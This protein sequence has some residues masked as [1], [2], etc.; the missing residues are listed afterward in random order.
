MPSNEVGFM[1]GIGGAHGNARSSLHTDRPTEIQKIFN[2]RTGN[3]GI[4]MLTEDPK[5]TNNTIPRRLGKET[6]SRQ[7]KSIVDKVW[8]ANNFETKTKSSESDSVHLLRRIKRK[9]SPPEPLP[10]IELV[11]QMRD[12]LDKMYKIPDELLAPRESFTEWAI[13]ERARYKQ[14]RAALVEKHEKSVTETLSMEG[15]DE[16]EGYDSVT[17]KD[18]IRRTHRKDIIKHISG[19]MYGQFTKIPKLP[20]RM[21]KFG[22]PLSMLER[23][24][25][26]S[27]KQQEKNKKLRRARIT[28]MKLPIFFDEDNSEEDDVMETVKTLT[29][30]RTPF[31]HVPKI[32]TQK[33]RRRDRLRTKYLKQDRLNRI[34]MLLYDRSYIPSAQISLEKIEKSESDEEINGIIKKTDLSNMSPQHKKFVTFIKEAFDEQVKMLHKEKTDDATSFQQFKEAD[35]LRTKS[36]TPSEGFDFVAK[37]D[38]EP[39]PMQKIRKNEKFSKSDEE[40]G[41]F[42]IDP[43]KIEKSRDPS[44][45]E[46]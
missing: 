36:T 21:T 35:G 18:T 43:E 2:M 14:K 25:E 27:E 15:N 30:I 20:K 7:V 31:L 45:C 9:P 22:I 39:M 24:K 13:R 40:T 10:T 19:Y 42:Y 8:M 1:G 44:K 28:H 32:K 5:A 23:A 33:K 29:L 46:Y 11:N 34:T 26:E 16:S 38:V 6:Y 4:Y 41:A 37:Q 17:M 3:R 12:R